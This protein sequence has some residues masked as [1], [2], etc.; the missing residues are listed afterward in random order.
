MMMM[1]VII[2]IIII[3]TEDCLAENCALLGYYLAST[4][5]F[6]QA[7]RDNLAIPSLRG[8]IGCP[9]TSVRNYRYS[10]IHNP[11][12]AVLTDNHDALLR[13]VQSTVNL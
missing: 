5:N 13:F 3:I 12:S 11:N 10:L 1:M 2:I 8:P 4:G 9:E 7:F 6:L